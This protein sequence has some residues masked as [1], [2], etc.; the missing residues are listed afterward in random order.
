MQS[1]YLGDFVCWDHERQ[2]ELLKREYGWKE[3]KVEGS[4]KRYK[5]VE[6]VMPGVHDYAKFIKRG[7]GRGTDF[8]SQDVRSGL[9]TREEAFEVAGKVDSEAPKALKKY[10][11]ITGYTEDEFYEILRS[12]REGAAIDLP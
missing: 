4:F 11:E 8:A 10:L 12:Q 5:S 3:D 2:T 9:M 6:C 1:I 7:Y